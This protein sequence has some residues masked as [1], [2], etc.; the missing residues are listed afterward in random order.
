[1]ALYLEEIIKMNLC[2]GCGS[3][4]A[5]CPENCIDLVK[6]VKETYYPK[7]DYDKCIN[8]NLCIKVCP[9]INSMKDIDK[10][11][12]KY[13]GR[14]NLLI[15]N[16]KDCYIGYSKSSS[17]RFN[18]ASGGIITTLL[19]FLLEKGLING[20]LLTKM[21]SSNSMEAVPFIARTRQEILSAMGS[22]YVPVPLNRILKTLKNEEGEFAIVGLPCHIKGIR[23]IEKYSREYRSK[24]KYHFGLFCSHYVSYDGVKYI[25]EKMGIRSKDVKNIKFRGEG[26]P[27]KI[28]IQLKNGNIKHINYLDSF[29][30]DAY[31]SYLFCPYSCV[32]CNDSTSEY[33]DL[34]FGDSYL[35]ETKDDKT[36]TSIVISRT[37]IGGS[38][39]RDA[40]KD[41]KIFLSGID[42]HMVIESQMCPLFF[43]KR[44][45]ISRVNFYKRVKKFLPEISEEPEGKFIAPAKYDK[46]AAAFVFT[47]NYISKSY[48]LSFFLKCA[49]QK[50]LKKVRRIFKSMIL[51]RSDKEIKSLNNNRELRVFVINSHSNNRGDEA[52]QRSMVESIRRSFPE[53]II[54]VLTDNPDGLDIKNNVERIK[55]FHFSYR[56]LLI[57]TIWLFLKN[58]GFGFRRFEKKYKFLRELNIMWKSDIVISAPG[59]PYIGDLYRSHEIS[60]LLQIYFAKKMHKKVM[61]YAPSMGPFRHRFY[62][63]IRKRILN[64]VEVITVRDSESYKN[65]LDFNLPKPLVYL[66]A[67]SAI[68]NEI[69]FRRRPY[70][71]II[72]KFKEENKI[73]EDEILVGFTPAGYE[74]NNI[75]LENELNG[76]KYNKIIST[77]LDYMIENYNIRVVIF[78]QLYGVD[79]DLPLINGITSR[80]K[81]REKIIVFDNRLDSFKQ[82]AVISILDFFVSNRYHPL[83]FSLLAGIP[84]I[85]ISYQFKI[86][87]LMERFG[88]GKFIIDISQLSNEI[89][90]EKFELLVNDEREVKKTIIKNMRHMKHE[91]SL[92]PIIFK[93]LVNDGRKI[94]E[95]EVRKYL[96]E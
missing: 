37:D 95:K 58:V 33:S 94:I 93:L 88:M 64:K 73:K 61:I 40:I 24:I 76:E 27:G 54:T 69:N 19:L 14:F 4:M 34:S 23:R 68:G 10:F 48:I 77:F 17:I 60:H 18:A 21:G 79:T 38:L 16:Y 59:G 72:K 9:V 86:K 45:I 22:K 5:I 7:I 75:S 91:A 81:K 82:Q 11:L 30:S 83:I 78:P 47:N 28:S 53:S 31:G 85:G 49:P 80:V 12:F 65:L 2:N 26:W 52:A 20:A 29:W 57:I 96:K 71:E 50:L 63:F 92:N 70:N 84:S 55:F 42:E 3:C 25:L 35:D 15:G 13:Q 36:G 41:R 62:N 39:L 89:L 90:P 74:W 32:F 46:L 56:K 87:N 66:T 8:C 51:Y 1:M 44:N 6:S 43:K 67:D